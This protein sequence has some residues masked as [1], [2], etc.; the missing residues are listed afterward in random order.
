M[1]V[2]CVS[3]F[4]ISAPTLYT[5]RS[6]AALDVYTCSRDK[7]D[8]GEDRK[9]EEGRERMIEGRVRK[10]VRDNNEAL[11][12]RVYIRVGIRAMIGEKSISGF[13]MCFCRE[14]LSRLSKHFG[15]GISLWVVYIRARSRGGALPT[16]E[17]SLSAEDMVGGCQGDCVLLAL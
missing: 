17:R 6:P 9:R 11:S 13:V 14:A 8:E 12:A 5:P 4:I 2:L 15:A 10:D 7:D 16:S 3:D 1:Y